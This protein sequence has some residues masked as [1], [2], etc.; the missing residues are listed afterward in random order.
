MES[1]QELK[2]YLA[3]NLSGAPKEE[4]DAAYNKLIVKADANYKEA[5]DTDEG[6]LGLD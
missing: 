2:D 6:V 1:S 3:A 4:V 5:N